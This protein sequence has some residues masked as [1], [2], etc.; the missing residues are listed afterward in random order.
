MTRPRIGII[1]DFNP[2]YLYHRAT[3]QA[4]EAAAR[5]LGVEM[6]YA[7]AP[8][9]LIAEKGVDV[10]REFDALWASPGSPYESMDGA[11]E[12]IRFARESGRPFV[13]T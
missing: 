1:G 11:L 2:E 13:G 9:A 3:N 6:V 7:W 12:G 10:L 4:L 8:T 5:K